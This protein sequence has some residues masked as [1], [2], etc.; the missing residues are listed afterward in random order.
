MPTILRR[1]IAHSRLHFASRR[2]REKR[3]TAANADLDI[4]EFII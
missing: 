1:E 3:R 4:T 2:P